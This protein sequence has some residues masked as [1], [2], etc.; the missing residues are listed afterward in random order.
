MHGSTGPATTSQTSS[1]LT[2]TSEP[3][4]CEADC[5][6][7]GETGASAPGESTDVPV[8]D[9]G[10]WGDAATGDRDDADAA[11]ACTEA[12][13]CGTSQPGVSTSDGVTSGTDTASS[14]SSSG[15][16]DSSEPVFDECPE[17]EQQVERGSCGC[18]FEPTPA[19]ETLASHLVHRYTFDGTGTT[20]LDTVG[21]VSGEIH[22]CELTGTSQLELSG[23]DCHAA[24][25]QG[26]ISGL[27]DATFEFW[28]RWDGGEDDQRIFNFGAPGEGIRS[29]SS[30]ISL[31]P[32]AGNRRAL[33]V[34][35]LA[36]PDGDSATLRGDGALA[37]GRVEHVAVV[38][39]STGGRLVL[40]R[41]GQWDAEMNSAQNLRE[42]QD[43]KVW[44]GRALYSSYPYFRGAIL[45]FRIYDTALSDAEL[46]Q[47]ALL[48][49]DAQVTQSTP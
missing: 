11:T 24:L 49:P 44:L 3:S 4:G 37:T 17:Q 27:T 9:A 29:P 1:S 33:S 6:D 30:F 15:D 42:L 14:T 21:G 10:P 18:G 40:Y 23:D 34:T 22:N 43:E 2:A 46:S 7:A 38:V 13:D 41:A 12:L 31:S 8:S 16:D 28:V 25:P 32:L 48:G 35:Y 47:S 5:G 39:D 20:L 36:D 26:S 19:C 45:E